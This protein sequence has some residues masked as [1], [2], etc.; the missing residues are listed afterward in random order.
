MSR[1]RFVVRCH[2]PLAEVLPRHVV[3]T[4]TLN[5]GRVR[6]NEVEAGEDPAQKGDK[7]KFAHY[8]EENNVNQ[9][10]LDSGYA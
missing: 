4:P 1:S 10:L 9:T 3:N 8:P 2:N 5:R 6:V 7:V